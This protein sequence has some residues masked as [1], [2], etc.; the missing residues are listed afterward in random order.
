MPFPT[1]FR[2][3]DKNVLPTYGPTDRRTDG[4][5]DQWTNGQTDP[6]IEMLLMIN[7]NFFSDFMPFPL[8][9]LC[10]KKTRNGPTDGPTDGLT[11]EQTLI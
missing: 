9:I 5:T 11:D 6:H 8:K 3:L 2:G 4:R 1:K 10:L 7:I